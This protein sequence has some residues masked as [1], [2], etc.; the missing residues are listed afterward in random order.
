MQYKVSEV[1]YMGN[2]VTANGLKPD[3]KKI[4]AIVNMP[5]PDDV[6][7]LQRFLGMTKYLSQYI[8]NESTITAPLRT[9]L[10]QDAKW[11]WKPEHNIA[12]AELKN[13]LVTS[14]TL[15][16]Y[17]VSKPVT[18]QADASK[19]GLG[20]CLLQEGKPVAYA[21]RSMSS[22]ECNY[23]QIEKEMLAIVFSCSKFHQ[24]I[25]GKE[26]VNV[27][28]DHKPLESILK[29]PL[30]KAPPRLQRMM[31]NLQPYDLRVQYVPGK[32]MHAADTLSRAYVQGQE[33]Q[34]LE[35][36]VARV[37]HTLLA[38]LPVSPH[39][40]DEIQTATQKD[41]TLQKVL[42]YV[43]TG[44]PSSKKQAFPSTKPFWHLRDELH[45]AD[46]ILF[47]N[48]RIVIPAKLQSYMLSLLHESHFGIE[49]TK[50][51]A[52]PVM[53]WPGMSKDIE[54]TIQNCAICCRF[55]RSNTKEPMISHDI[56]EDPFEKVATDIFTFDGA[57]YLVVVDY[58]SKYPEICVLKDKTA[59]TV[60]DNLK[61]VFARHG[62]P[63]EIVSDN[64]PFASH[65][66]KEFAESWGIQTITSSPEY[67][68]SNGQAER[69]VQ[70]CKNILRK[71]S[72]EN[73]D[74]H[75]ALMEYRNTPLSGLKYAPSQLLMSRLLRTKIPVKKSLLKPKVINAHRE[76]L[77]RQN[78]QKKYYDRSSKPLSEL[79]AGDS[80]YIKR[81]KRWESAVV[82][83]KHSAPRSYIVETNSGR[84]RR[85]RRHLRSSKAKFV[86]KPELDDFDYLEP[87]CHDTTGNASS[88]SN[89]NNLAST[90]TNLSIPEP[91]QY[92]TRFGRL[93]KTPAK[94][95][96]FV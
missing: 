30:C 36:D 25:F 12:I 69:C 32:L 78:L 4:N 8:P 9:L 49:K 96:D 62:I 1:E 7:S 59:K 15:A 29:K 68:I 33:N 94:Y 72:E 26:A 3:D 93:V 10:K 47:A 43:M 14:P 11:E 45:Y 85:N 88:D 18:I 91:E 60:I 65:E 92:M 61:S 44:W 24:Y 63:R 89:N 87:L 82:A 58:Y 28:T 50:S 23:A 77:N 52:R 55:Q 67:P 37:I 76:L 53:Y 90:C 6:P 95:H 64:M 17:D 73:R 66:F 46:G 84:F 80:A 35:D 42:H 48:E 16:F 34:E 75:I 31:L 2:F 51:R 56:P 54:N 81:G 74:P 70:T 27:Q 39:K 40:F 57:D 5:V 41:E 83:Q 86:S 20:A 22:A 38:N 13:A 79:S 71:A 21:S 19:S